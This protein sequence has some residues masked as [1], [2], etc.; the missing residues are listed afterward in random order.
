MGQK[1]FSVLLITQVALGLLFSI[2]FSIYWHRKE[3]KNKINSDL[4]HAWFHGLIRYWLAFSVSTYGFAKIMKTQFDHS[5]YTDDT[6]VRQLNGFELTWNYFSHSYVFAVIIALCQLIGSILLLFRRTTLLGALIL[7]PVMINILLINFFFDITPGALLNSIVYTIGLLYLFLLRWADFKSVL[8]KTASRLPPV[9][10]G[11]LKYILRSLAITLAFIMIYILVNR[12]RPSV[13]AGKWKVDQYIRNGDTVPENLW[14]T[15]PTVWKNI[16][17]EDFGKLILSPNPYVYDVD[18]AQWAN[19]KYDPS[20][21]ELQLFVERGWTEM[22]TIVI[23]VSNY[24]KNQMQWNTI[25][26]KDTLFI[27]LSKVY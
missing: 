26:K 4:I 10:L 23:G 8:F 18:R 14:I 25:F 2:A 7:L 9:R 12:D 19:F 5:Y 1:I 13:L 27:K 21:Q 11:I 24:N 16:Y 15:D 3:R 22:D 20:K 17:I 6:V